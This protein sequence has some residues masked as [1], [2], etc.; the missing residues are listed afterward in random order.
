MYEDENCE[1]KR[2]FSDSIY[3]TVVAFANTNGGDIYVGIDDTGAPVGLKNFDDTYNRITNGIR[4]NIFPDVSDIVSYIHEEG[5]IIH[6]KVVDSINKPFCLKSKGFRPEG[7]Y[8]RKGAS[9]IP[10]TWEMIKK[11]IYDSN[12]VWE[13]QISLNQDLS[14]NETEKSFNDY[15]VAFDKS[16]FD[17][18]NIINKDYYTNL[19][20]LLSDNCSFS[21]KVA[22]FSDISCTVFRDKQEF[23][24]SVLKQFEDANRYLDFANRTASVIEKAQRIDTRDYPPAA[25]REAVLNAIIHK[26]YYYD[27]SVIININDTKIEFISIG[28][29]MPGFSIEDIMAGVSSQRNP[30]LANVFFRL[31]LIEA[32][33]TGIRRIYN[34]YENYPMKPEI[35]VTDNS[36]KIILPNIN[37]MDKFGQKDKILNYIRQHGQ[38]LEED[39]EKLFGVRSTRAYKIAKDL[40]DA[41]ILLKIGRGKTKKYIIKP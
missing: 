28:G 12:G 39:I 4:D 5:D 17:V 40:C 24:G 15:N 14:F 2:E 41:G 18:L 9:N 23:K 30:K 7:V 33:G 37:E 35:F 25:L 27:G 16:K 26:N 22:V 6:I 32:Y 36:F 20:F 11:M 8:I 3:K 29:L 31:G 1:F 21:V 10:A 34:L 13:E 38:I 19:G